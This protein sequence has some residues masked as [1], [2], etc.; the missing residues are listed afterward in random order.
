MIK[1]LLKRA[2]G[3]DQLIAIREQLDEAKILAAKA[4]INQIKAHG[5]YENLRETEFKVFSQFGDDGI[6]QYLV[7]NIPVAFEQQSFIEFGVENYTESNTRF[8]LLNNNWRGLV[9][10]GSEAQVSYIK[11]DQI[12]WKHDLTAVQSFITTDNI[13]RIISEHNFAGEIGLLSIDIDGNDYW[14]WKAIDAVSPF[15]VI[16]EYNSVFGYEHEITIPYDPAFNRTQAHP[17][18][19][20][21]GCSLKALVMLAERKGYAFVGSNSAGNNAYFVRKDKLGKVKPTSLEDGYVYSRFRESRD[22]Q[23]RLTYLSGTQR[24]TAIEE[25]VVYHLERDA[26]VKIKDL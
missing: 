25:M 4:L 1:H 21:W 13:N 16:V 5:V 19:L 7:E 15:V 17:S 9:M 20:F 22:E 12:Y 24:L 11:S 10:D 26:P 2:T 3:R 6:I 8:L 18:N 23:G 14:V